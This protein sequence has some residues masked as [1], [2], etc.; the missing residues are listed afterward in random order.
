MEAQAKNKRANLLTIISANVRGLLTNIGDLT[1]TFVN[2][3]NVDIV[4][5]VETFF[6]ESVPQNYGKMNGYSN[7]FRRDRIGREKGGIAVCF[8]NS[9]RVQ[10][11]DVSV[12]DHL[13][14]IFFKIWVNDT[15][16]ILFCT[17]YRPQWQGGQPIDFL[18]RNLDDLMVQHAC[19]HILVVGDMNQNL[20]IRSFED[21]L[22]VYGLE[23]HV[24]FPTH[25]S[26]SSLDPVVTDLP[27]SLV[28]CRS[29][30]YV[31]SSDHQAIYTAIEICPQY[32]EA[33]TRTTWL[34][35]KGD[36]RGM[37]KALSSVK[38][39]NI[40]RGNV[41]EQAETFTNLILDMMYLYIPY[42][43]YKVKP[44]DQPWFGYHCRKAADEKSKAW[45]RYKR[46]PTERN[47]QIHLN[48]CK[49]MKDTQ[50]WAIKRWQEDLKTKLTGKTVGSK[51]W[52]SLIK[53]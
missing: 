14:L 10:P 24:N 42:R 19:K 38:W 36:W 30:G 25:I 35:N 13:E 49:R 12:P 17:C 48:A 23:N 21:W 2:V 51:S 5:T 9:L 6:N 22:D 32:D 7:W 43:I 11:L 18:H 46:F 40:L 37:R 4:A 16:T 3:H 1:H 27:S 29:L 26:G 39:G 50:N 45:T 53:Q 41:N 31:G 8:K 15:D 52:W 33:V 34:W 47:K 44:S 28:S 20:I